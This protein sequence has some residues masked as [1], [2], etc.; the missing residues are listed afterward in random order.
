MNTKVC[1][2]I[3]THWLKIA[4]AIAG[5]ALSVTSAWALMKKTVDEHDVKLA[6]IVQI[7]ARDEQSMFEQKAVLAGVA[8]E[9]HDLHDWMEGKTR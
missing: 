6:Q 3:D 7:Q 9:V 5:F 2:F 8:Q 1:H 4:I